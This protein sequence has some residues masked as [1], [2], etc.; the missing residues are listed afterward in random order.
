MSYPPVPV[1]NGFQF[2]STRHHDTYPFIDPT[3][4]SD[5]T[6]HYVLVTGASKGVGRATAISFARAGA[7]GIA[8]GAR[9]DFGTLEQEIQSAAKAASKPAPKVLKLELDVADY[10]SV[11]KAAKVVEKE[12]G[13]LDVLIN[14]AGYLGDWVP[15]ADTDP[16]GWWRNYEIN[17]GGTYHVS[18]AFMPLLL[19]SGQ[20]TIVNVTSAGAHGLGP[21]ASG[22]QGSK[23]ALLRFTEFL[24]VDYQDQGLLA[25]AVHP[26]GTRTELGENMPEHMYRV[27]TDTPEIAA[28]AMVF[29][30]SKKR[31]WLAGRYVD[32]CWD[33]E[34]F[35]SKEKEVVEGDKLKMRMVL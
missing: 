7:A 29:L 31:D 35:L 8:L 19:K 28:D 33:M 21:G 22:Y 18:K 20:K 26:C 6:N 16:K 30:T 11:E 9:S 27:F 4:Q 15:V 12:F 2:V 5:H 14:N 17:V 13:K 1:N 3:T 24:M 10:A 25:Y 34:E 32:C 23:F